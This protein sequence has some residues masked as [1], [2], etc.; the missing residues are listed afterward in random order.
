MLDDLLDKVGLRDGERVLDIGCG[1]GSFAAHA[2][3]RLPRVR[4]RGLTLS[5]VQAEYIRE[6]QNQPGHPFHG[7]RFSLQEGDFNDAAFDRPFDCIVSIG[8]FEHVSNLGKALAKIRALLAPG[9]RCFLHYIVF[10]PV[11]GLPGLVAR[12]DPVL[13]RYVFPGGRIWASG[14]VFRHQ[15]DLRIAAHWFVNGANYRKTLQAWLGNFLR[16]RGKILEEAGLDERLM[17]LWEVYLRGCIAVFGVRGG[18][19]Y[20]NGQYLF[21]AP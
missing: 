11:V 16:H 2:L 13:N 15:N 9:G 20:G 7:G 5:R 14:E 10:T 18:R 21:R 3:R 1:F 12:Q 6:R 4:V 19:A 8:V 17:R